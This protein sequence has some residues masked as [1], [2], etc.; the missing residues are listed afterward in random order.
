MLAALVALAY[1]VVRAARI[2]AWRT[3]RA[4]NLKQIGLAIHNYADV[5]KVLPPT[6]IR[7]AQCRLTASWRLRIGPYLEASGLWFCSKQ[8]W[9]HPESYAWV[10]NP[11]HTFCFDAGSRSNPPFETN[12]VAITG[13]GTAFEAGRSYR[14]A[15][16]APDTILAIEIKDSGI[17]WAEP[18]DLDIREIRQSIL[19]GIDGHG[20][21]VLFADGVVGFVPKHVPLYELM[22]FFTVEGAIR[23]DRRELGLQR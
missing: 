16:L 7:D 2:A 11:V 14:L 13:P 15:D 5:W 12:V 23:H 10:L 22:E 6:E 1:P 3:Q 9:D 19:T 20:V 21:L 18:G 4:N 17:L 8:D